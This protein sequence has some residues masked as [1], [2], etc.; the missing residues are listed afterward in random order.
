MTTQP[1]F[2]SHS[3]E[4][5]TFCCELV[6]ALRMPGVDVWYDEQDLGPGRLLLTIDHEMRARPIFVVI[7]SPAALASG[8]VRDESSWAYTLQQH[9]PHRVILP[10]LARPVDASAVWVFLRDFKRIEAPGGLPLAPAEAARQTLHAITLPRRNPAVEQHVYDSDPLTRARALYARNRHAEALALLDRAAHLSPRGLPPEALALRAH[11][12]NRLGQPAEALAAAD[13]ALAMR[14]NG[15]E[16]L[17]ARA[18]ALLELRRFKEAL[19]A[20]EHALDQDP[21]QLAGWVRKAEIHSWLGEFAEMLVA[22]E[23]ALRLDGADMTALAVRGIALSGL[24]HTVEARQVLGRA[25]AACDRALA[26]RADDGDA[27]IYK[28]AVLAWLGKYGDALAAY[29]HA[30]ALLPGLP[31]LWIDKARMLRQLG[32]THEAEAAEARANILT[33]V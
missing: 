16:A 4:D 2:V 28:G 30:L 6:N 23:R 14:P 1:I 13:R 22:A 21:T 31:S 20:A 9:E 29:E 12:L 24:H 7:F 19:T 11:T 5:N 18:E 32:R 8:W 10:V 26:Q 27:W 33:S 17:L 25:L 3:H 15:I